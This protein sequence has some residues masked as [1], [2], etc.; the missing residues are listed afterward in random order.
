MPMTP[1]QLRDHARYLWGGRWCVALARKLDRDPAEI[2]DMEAG[3][4]PID[5]A[6]IDAV[7]EGMRDRR[8][9]LQRRLE[10]LEA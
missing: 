3:R 2:F 6:V 10:M 9:G 8:D 5:V 4:M 7:A 1:R